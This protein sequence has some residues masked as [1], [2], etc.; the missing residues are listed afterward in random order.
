VASDTARFHQHILERLLPNG[1]SYAAVFDKI[2]EGEYTLASR[3][4]SRTRFGDHRRYGLASRL[5]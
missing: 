3:S 4:G 1:T 2:T 5:A